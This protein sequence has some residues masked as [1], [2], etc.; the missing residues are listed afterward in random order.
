MKKNII[1][2]VALCVLAGCARQNPEAAP[3]GP[4]TTPL[5]PLQVINLLPDIPEPSDIAWNR[6]NNSLMVVSDARPDIFEIGFDGVIHKTIPAFGSDLEGVAASHTGDTLF[7]VEERNQLV[8]SFDAQGR[9]LNAFPV[10][11]ATTENNALEGVAV[12]SQGHIWVLNEKEPRLLLEF[13]GT[14]ELFR[15]EITFARDLSG[16][17][18]DDSGE[19][20]WIIS[21]ESRKVIKISRSGALLAEWL[22]PFDKGEGIAFVGNKMYVVNDQ[23][24]KLYIFDKPQ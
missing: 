11:V 7:V 2:L 20:L 5:R 22:L 3:T 23:D 21:D 6:K 14:Q 10:K 9:R 8:V 13:K 12:D 19:A 4:D 16:I 24:A 1:H 17:C 15:K 18:C